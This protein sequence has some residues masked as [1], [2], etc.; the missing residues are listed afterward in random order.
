MPVCAAPS[1]GERDGDGFDLVCVT[2]KGTLMCLHIGEA[3][4][5]V[6]GCV[7]LGA[8]WHVVDSK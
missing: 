5:H 7:S 3:N 2:D 1:S 4:I 6:C 8:S